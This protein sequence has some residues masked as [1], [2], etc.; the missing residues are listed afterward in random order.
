VNLTLVIPL[1]ATGG[2]HRVNK[3]AEKMQSEAT[4]N[5]D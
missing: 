2:Y 4:V 3:A 1:S 5:S